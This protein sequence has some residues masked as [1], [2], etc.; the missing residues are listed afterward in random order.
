VSSEARNQSEELEARLASAL[1]DYEDAAERTASG[2]YRCRD[3]GILFDTLEA[4]DLHRRRVH[5]REEPYPISSM[6]M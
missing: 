2:K 5:G 6:V 4:H 3:C 1:Q